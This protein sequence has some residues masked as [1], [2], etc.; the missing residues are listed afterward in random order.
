MN[1]IYRKELGRR[2]G[3]RRRAPEL[4][5]EYNEK[6]ANPY[7]AAGLGYLDDVIEPRETRPRL[8]ARS[9]M[10]AHKRQPSP[11]RST[12]TSRSEGSVR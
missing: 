5:A 11:R 2:E 12:A 1:I 4:V 3:P 6:F 7:I 9:R 10:L 8:I